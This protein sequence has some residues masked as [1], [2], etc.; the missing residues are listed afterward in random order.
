MPFETF[1]FTLFSLINFSLPS[2]S[3]WSFFLFDN[4]SSRHSF[5]VLFYFLFFWNNRIHWTRM[6]WWL[7]IQLIAP[8]IL[9][10]NRLFVWLLSLA[11]YSSFS[12][13][14]YPGFV[15]HKQASAFPS[16]G[17]IQVVHIHLCCWPSYSTIYRSLSLFYTHTNPQS[18]RILPLPSS[19]SGAKGR[20][21]SCSLTVY[22]ASLCIHLSA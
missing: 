6:F 21:R 20:R 19:V 1:F 15:W 14:L 16:L 12:L 4:N 9:I 22:P 2:P 13:S 10:A 7:G 3:L 17:V 11:C 8:R 5:R 18:S